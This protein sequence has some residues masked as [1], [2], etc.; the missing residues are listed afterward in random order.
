MQY[1]IRTNDKQEHAITKTAA[2]VMDVIIEAMRHGMGKMADAACDLI[3]RQGTLT[4]DECST[5][6]HALAF[7]YFD[8]KEHE[9]AV[10][11]MARAYRYGMSNGGVKHEQQ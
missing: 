5:I 1:T 6:R 4:P 10:A 11:D 2:S 3:K 7:T 8:N 9:R